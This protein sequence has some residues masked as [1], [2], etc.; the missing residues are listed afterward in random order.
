[1]IIQRMLLCRTVA[2]PAPYMVSSF[3]SKI[4]LQA[5]VTEENLHDV[6]KP[7]EE[8]IS[9]S[10]G[11]EKEVR[12]LDDMFKQSKDQVEECHDVNIQD[13]G[14]Q[15]GAKLQVRFTKENLDELS[16]W[17]KFN[18]MTMILTE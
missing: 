9:H 12:T 7:L 15:I 1:M 2:T 4:P 3:K 14:W 11:V 18:H 8:Y 10:M 6:F 5:C 13:Q 16:P 17:Q